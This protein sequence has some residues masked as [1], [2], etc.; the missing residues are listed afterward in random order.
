MGLCGYLRLEGFQA[1]L[2]SVELN[3]RGG[4]LEFKERDQSF[5]AKEVKPGSGISGKCYGI[6]NLS[7]VMFNVRLVGSNTS[8]VF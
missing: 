4:V 5:C 3:F 6:G 8:V 2:R 1:Q 7:Y